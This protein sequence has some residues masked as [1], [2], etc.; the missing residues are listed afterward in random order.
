MKKLIVLFLFF[1]SF[2]PAQLDWEKMEIKNTKIAENIYRLYVGEG[3]AVI[4]S[5]GED[6]VLLIDA[7]YEQTGIKILN[8]LEKIGSSNL[9]YIVNTHWH[10]D[11]TGGNKFLGENID[12]ISHNYVKELLSAEQELF[13]QKKEAYPVFARPNI[14][15]SDEMNLTF[16]N[17]EIIFKH[18]RGGHTGGDIIIY[19]KESNVLCLG[20]LLFADNFPFVDIDHGGNAIRLIEHLEWISKTYPED[21]V[22]IGGHGKI[23]TIKDLV[24]YHNDLSETVKIIRKAISEGLTEEEMAEKKLLGKWKSYGEWFIDEKFWIN[25]IIRSL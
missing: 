2:L 12:I 10:N 24:K 13:G 20:D 25:T 9:K 16:N 23:Y 7:A 3:V 1:L 19:F 5:V 6:G 8:E 11:H 15:F 4:A 21:V 18:L 22:L 17:Q 14:T